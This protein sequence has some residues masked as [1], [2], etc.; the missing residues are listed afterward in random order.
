MIHLS[1]VGFTVVSLCLKESLA[2]LTRGRFVFMCTAL[3]MMVL[4]NRARVGPTTKTLDKISIICLF[5]LILQ[6]KSFVLFYL[7]YSSCF[8]VKF[9][10]HTFLKRCSHIAMWIPILLITEVVMSILSNRCA[11]F[12]VDPIIST[13]ARSSL[14]FLNDVCF[15]RPKLPLFSRPPTPFSSRTQIC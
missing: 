13:F 15:I 10:I 6:A 4:Y 11:S 3:Y 14:S 8:G 7:W 12:Q 1:T 5:R 2:M 9:W